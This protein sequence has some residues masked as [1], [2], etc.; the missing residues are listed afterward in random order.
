MNDRSHITMLGSMPPI[1]GISKYTYS[2][3]NEL[4]KTL[5]I[6]FL[7]F[8]NIYPRFLYPGDPVDRSI[9]RKAV[10]GL[11]IVEKLS[12]YNPF[13]WIAAG[14]SIST[15]I[16]HAQWWSYVLAPVYFTILLIARIKGIRIILTVHNVLPHESNPV[17]NI[18]NRMVIFLA[19]EIIVHTE[20]SRKSLMKLYGERF[21]EDVVHIVPHGI[22]VHESTNIITRQESRRILNIADNES[23][24][25]IFGNIRD[26]KGLDIALE[27]LNILN[28]AGFKLKLI[29]AGTVWGNWAKYERIIKRHQIE[30]QVVLDLQY[31]PDEK[32]NTYL[33]ASDIVLLTYRSFE[34]QS[35]VGSV[36]LGYDV[37]LLVSP[38]GGLPDYVGHNP[39][40][41]VE[42]QPEAVARAIQYI[43]NNDSVRKEILASM[44]N[45]RTNLKWSGIAART[46]DIYEKALRNR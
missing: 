42:P 27:A 13:G 33:L 24:A 6:T 21:S 12:W 44:E 31:I 7:S 5:R 30:D 37:P 16:L 18:L 39:N 9:R 40:A 41:I 25:L 17:T 2:L 43:C 35:G 15:A 14:L 22:I 46:V 3:C 1:K 11:E 23:A 29:V 4:S 19:H 10:E 45:A 20:D 36:A 28:S 26:Y 8:R 32:I 34:S 38:V